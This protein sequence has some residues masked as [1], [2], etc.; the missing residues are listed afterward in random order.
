MST[1]ST[2]W[3]KVRE[4]AK[5]IA[6]FV[7]GVVGSVIV[8][9]FNGSTPWPS[10]QA[11]WVQLAIASFGPAIATWLTTNKI[12]QKQLDKDPHVI[13]GVVVPENVPAA[14]P[15]PPPSVGGYQPPYG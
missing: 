9:L 8:N 2:I 12:T 6:A 5:T 14:V 15:P 11:E 7:A 3:S 10:N 4:Y 1:V 13:G